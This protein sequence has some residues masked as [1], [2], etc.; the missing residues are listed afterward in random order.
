MSRWQLLIL[1]VAIAVCFLQGWYVLAI[2]GV[3]ATSFFMS[4]AWFLP[5]GFLI[6]G[7]FGMWHSVPVLSLSL[8]AW[9]V[10]FELLRPHISVEKRSTI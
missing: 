2:V 8:V 10:F 1:Y 5:L 3:L 9:F 4:T 6:D 7:Y